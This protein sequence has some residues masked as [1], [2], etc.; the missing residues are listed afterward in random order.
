MADSKHTKRAL[1]GSALALILCFA[2]LLGTTFAWFTD[3]ASTT[4]NTI[5][6]GTLD[7][8]ITTEGGKSL[9]GVTMEF[10]GKGGINDAKLWEPGAIYELT[11]F[12]IVN[13]GNLA[14]KCKIVVN[15]IDGN[16]KL[17][18]AIDFQV[19]TKVWENVDVSGGNG[20]YAWKLVDTTMSLSELN[21]KEFV[22][23][24]AGTTFGDALD[25]RGE[26]QLFTIM[27]RMDPNA[28]NEYQGLSL[29]GLG[30]TILAT[31]AEAEEDINGS[32][33]DAPALYP[34]ESYPG[35]P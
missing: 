9:D 6:A 34:G 15:G 33:Y 24:A 13:K 20:H 8:D 29:E 16:E 35:E 14:V 7:V 26:T 4:V 30:L 28:G 22:I 12:K 2:M 18:E 5:Q 25:N 1:L 21:N 31:Q 32:D 10:H 27:A 11:P 23:Y 19:A 17:L 3:T